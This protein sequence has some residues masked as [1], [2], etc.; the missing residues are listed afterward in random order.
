MGSPTRSISN[1]DASS[2]QTAAP[3]FFPRSALSPLMSATEKADE[4]PS[5]VCPGNCEKLEISIEARMLRSRRASRTR[6]CS[7]FLGWSTYS[8]VEYRTDML[9]PGVRVIVTYTYLSIAADRTRPGDF[10]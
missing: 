9:L 7:S 10:L 2:A 3:S 1:R 8:A 4:E 6:R 5:P